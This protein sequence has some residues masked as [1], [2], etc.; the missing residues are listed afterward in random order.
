MVE[1][2]PKETAKLPGWLN[3]LLFAFLIILLLSLLSYFILNSSVKRASNVLQSLTTTLNELRSQERSA[4]EREVLK[5]NNKI[6]Y[7]FQLLDG[8]LETAKLFNLIEGSTHPQIWFT[9]FNLNAAGDKA[10][11]SG[12]T[13]NFANL[14]QQILIFKQSSWAS[15]TELQKVSISKEGNVDFELLVSIKPGILK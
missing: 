2:I 7:F 1:I 15:A 6:G 5:Y 9:K 8:H 11:F 10:V 3:N 4:A 13:R 12:K 14:G